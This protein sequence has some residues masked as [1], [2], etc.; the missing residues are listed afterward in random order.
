MKKIICKYAGMVQSAS[1]IDSYPGKT[2]LMF[3]EKQAISMRVSQLARNKKEFPQKYRDIM[4]E[5]R[6]T[7]FFRVFEDLG[8]YDEIYNGNFNG[9][10]KDKVTFNAD[11]GGAALYDAKTDATQVT[12]P[13]ISPEAML[14]SLAKDGDVPLRLDHLGH[15]IIHKKQHPDNPFTRHIYRFF[16]KNTQWGDSV[17]PGLEWMEVVAY[18]LTD[19]EPHEESD[20]YV[21]EHIRHARIGMRPAYMFTDR[22]QVKKAIELADN[23]IVAGAT[24]DELC[25]LAIT[26]GGWDAETQTFPGIEKRL[27]DLCVKNGISETDLPKKLEEY[28]VK[29]RQQKLQV[30]QIVWKGIGYTPVKK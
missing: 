22:N 18:R 20:A 10:K 8:L 2:E 5:I 17:I 29:K 21:E 15:E 13:P 3:P 1:M 12:G 11:I 23:L 6:N 30:Q 28:K 7:G 16:L 24:P 4:E 27:S 25:D 19:M 14:I 26:G 9:L